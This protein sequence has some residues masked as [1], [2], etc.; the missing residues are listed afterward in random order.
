M[1]ASLTPSP[2]IGLHV[3][4]SV[5]DGLDSLLPIVQMR[6][7]VPVATVVVKSAPN[8]GLLSVRTIGA[9]DPDLLVRR[10]QEIKSLQKRI[11]W[12]KKESARN[13]CL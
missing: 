6:R 7:G 10:T 8:A 12:R 9:G 13:A 4:A 2:V 1:A 11:N 3:R 5:M